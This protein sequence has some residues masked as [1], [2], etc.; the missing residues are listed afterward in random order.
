MEHSHPM[1][2]PLCDF[3]LASPNKN[4]FFSDENITRAMVF[5]PDGSTEVLPELATQRLLSVSP[6]QLKYYDAAVAKSHADLRV[7]A[8][9]KNGWLLLSVLAGDSVY[10][11]ILDIGFNQRQMG[12]RFPGW[13][14]SG[15]QA[16]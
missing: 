8:A 1:C 3:Q 13:G 4:K 12:Q 7:S 6:A 14:A 5:F 9:E 2:L 15:Y 16:F 10:E 11:G